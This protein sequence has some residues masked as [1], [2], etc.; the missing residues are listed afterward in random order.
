VSSLGAG[1]I[2]VAGAAV[3]CVVHVAAVAA[4]AAVSAFAGAM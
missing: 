4:V 3:E 1:F 2:V